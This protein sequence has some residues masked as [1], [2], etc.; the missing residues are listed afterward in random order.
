[1]AHI[2]TLNVDDQDQDAYRNFIQ[3]I[4]NTTGCHTVELFLNG[5]FRVYPCSKRAA[6]V[7][8]VSVENWVFTVGFIVGGQQFDVAIQRHK[9]YLV[10]YK[11]PNKGWIALNGQF[12]ELVIKCLDTS[13]PVWDQHG[14]KIPAHQ[15]K[16]GTSYRSLKKNGNVTR[17]DLKLNRD[18][19]IN[20]LRG[21]SDA[22]LDIDGTNRVP[23]SVLTL[24]QMIP[25]AV[26]I[27]PML[28]FI[29]EHYV[30]DDLT[31][32]NLLASLIML[33]GSWTMVSR[34]VARATYGLPFEE[35]VLKNGHVLRS[36]EEATAMFPY[37]RGVNLDELICE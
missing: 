9:L 31:T 10:A 6:Y 37:T 33:Q 34:A 22:Y 13:F 4:R 29:S 2:A 25:E 20:A 21:L 17:K 12:S 36:F 16:L 23:E 15:A 3:V 32:P 19:L 35:I 24:I 30:H 18:T 26:R 7:G 11:V 8:E 28:S 5:G 27:E 1:M 14:N